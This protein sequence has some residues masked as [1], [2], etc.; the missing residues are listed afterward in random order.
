MTGL[1]SGKPAG[2]RPFDWSR[3]AGGL[4]GLAVAGASLRWSY[5]IALPTICGKGA[6]DATIVAFSASFV[7]GA[8]ALPG[9]GAALFGAGRVRGAVRSWVQASLVMTLASALSTI[10]WIATSIAAIGPTL[11]R[12]RVA[13]ELAAPLG[14]AVVSVWLRV[15]LGSASE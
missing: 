5:P 14:A 13:G 3:G 8:L 1:F 15:R 11:S 12:A 4:I 2:R 7:L 6:L 9:F 10:G